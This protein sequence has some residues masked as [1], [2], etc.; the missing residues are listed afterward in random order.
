MASSAGVTE[1]LGRSV[2]FG[3]VGIVATAVYFLL[4]MALVGRGAGALPAHIIA[5]CAGFLVSYLGQKRFTFGI[6]GRHAA[7]GWRFVLATA[8]LVAATFLVVFV[9]EAFGAPARATIIANT[10]FYPAA[11]FVLHNAWT[12][13]LRPAGADG[14]AE[15]PPPGREP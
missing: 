7:A 2:R 15:T 11:S 3:I 9:L 8:A 10:V 6:R 13:R 12:F 5:L 4:G 1:F 14:Q